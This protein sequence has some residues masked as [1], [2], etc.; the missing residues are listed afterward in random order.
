MRG[1]GGC[2]GVVKAA[3]RLTE[4][5]ATTDQLYD[6]DPCRQSRDCGDGYPRLVDRSTAFT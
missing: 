5:G 6:I 4:V 2:G 1:Y 3:E